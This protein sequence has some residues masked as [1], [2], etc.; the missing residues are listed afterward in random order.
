MG[1]NL[2]ELI[3]ELI[4]EVEQELEEANITT[5]VDGYNTPFAFGG[6]KKR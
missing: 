5:S 6:R 4:Q 1:K 3:D 2:N